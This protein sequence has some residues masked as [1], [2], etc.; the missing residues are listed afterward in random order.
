RIKNDREDILTISVYPSYFVVHYLGD[1]IVIVMY[2]I[3]SLAYLF[4]KENVS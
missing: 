3:R 1:I 2:L 4:V